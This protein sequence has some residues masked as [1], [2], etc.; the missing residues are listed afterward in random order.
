MLLPQLLG[1]TVVMLLIPRLRAATVANSSASLI[2]LTVLSRRAVE[3]GVSKKAHGFFSYVVP[4]NVRQLP[5]LLKA[6]PADHLRQPVPG[7]GRRI[8]EQHDDLDR[9]PSDVGPGWH[10]AAVLAP[11]LL[12]GPDLLGRQGAATQLGRGDAPDC[13]LVA[14]QADGQH[15]VSSLAR[16]TAR[17]RQDSRRRRYASSACLLANPSDK[18]PCIGLIDQQVEL[19]ADI[20]EAGSADSVHRRETQSRVAAEQQEP[21]PQLEE[22]HQVER[23]CQD[24][25]QRFPGE[26][27]IAEG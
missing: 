16:S 25:D 15:R 10:Q 1:M 20:D 2:D 13:E 5:E 9:G 14:E 27:G 12:E 17:K 6:P 7:E 11:E 21:V 18:C 24:F 4:F 19:P 8:L 26:V 3:C 23:G 22:V